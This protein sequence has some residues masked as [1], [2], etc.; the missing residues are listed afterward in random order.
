[1]K[2]L[3]ELAMEILGGR[4]SQEEGVVRTEDRRRACVKAVGEARGYRGG[5][6]VAGADGWAGRRGRES[7][8]EG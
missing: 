7:V 3:K 6:T 5:G 4:L 2:E 8:R 1:M